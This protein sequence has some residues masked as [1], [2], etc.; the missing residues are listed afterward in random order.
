M[1]LYWSGLPLSSPRDL[2]NSGIK[3]RSLALQTDSLPSEPPGKPFDYLPMSLI[4][5]LTPGVTHPWESCLIQDEPPSTMGDKNWSWDAPQILAEFWTKR[6][7]WAVEY[8]PPYQLT[9]NITVT[10]NCSRQG[11]WAG[12]PWG[13]AGRKEHLPS[14]SRQNAA[15]S[16][17]E[18]WGTLDTKQD[19]GPR[20]LRCIWKEMISV[21]LDFCIFPY[22]EKC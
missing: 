15:T 8:F 13:N 11:R 19:T 14:S 20:E 17:G 16:H 6:R 18:L 4:Q 7:N 21:H 22:I 12:E 5:K 1:G 9:T 10:G 3:P 2:P